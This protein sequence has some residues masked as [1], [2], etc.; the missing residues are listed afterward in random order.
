MYKTHEKKLIWLSFI[1][2]GIMLLSLVGR[3]FGS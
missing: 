3:I 2:A 1:V